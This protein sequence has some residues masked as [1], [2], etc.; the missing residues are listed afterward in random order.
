[1]LALSD[2]TVRTYAFPSLNPQF[3]FRAHR[4]AVNAVSVVGDVIVSGSGDRSVRVWNANTGA[5]ISTFE[6]HHG[7]G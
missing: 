2:R 5:L 4:A 3:V 6:E 1:M 7:R